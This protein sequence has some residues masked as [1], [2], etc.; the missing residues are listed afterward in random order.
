MASAVYDN[1][2]VHFGIGEIKWDGAETDIY[3]LLHNN[4]A[5]TKTHGHYSDVKAQPSPQL[6]SGSGYT[7]GGNNVDITT[8]ALTSNVCKFLTNA[9]TAWTSASFTTYFALVAHG[10]IATDTNALISYHDLTGPQTVVNGTLTLQ[11]HA[12]GVF[13]ITITAES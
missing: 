2:M 13:T 7:T 8:C 3:A 4:T 9:N 11:W 5:P 12:D 1:A 6:A 10:P